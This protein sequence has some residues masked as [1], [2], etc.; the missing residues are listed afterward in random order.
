MKKSIFL[1]FLFCYTLASAQNTPAVILPGHTN[2]VD[3]VS[4]SSLGYIASGSFDYKINI[5]AADSPFTR[6]R[7]LTGHV[8]PVNTLRFSKNGKLLASSGEDHVVLVWDS[9][10]RNS[11]RLEG[12][13]DKVTCLAFDGYGRY[14]YSGSDDKNV[15]VWDMTTGKQVKTIV[16][17]TGVVAIAPTSDF[18]YVYIAGSEP[19]IKLYDFLTGKVAKSLDGHTD[20][21]NDIKISP[22]GKYL[23]SG[24]NDKTARVWSLTTGKQVRILPVECWKVT[25]VAFSADSRYAITACNDGSVKV[26]EIETGKLISSTEN[27]GSL[28][29]CV[30]FGKDNTIVLLASML[31]NSTDYG[32]KILPSGIK[33]EVA[34]VKV[35]APV[36]QDSLNSNKLPKIIPKTPATP[37]NSGTNMPKNA[38]PKQ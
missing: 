25:T 15:I 14:L 3:A 26:W 4:Y 37:P 10:W 35:V 33:P 22:N 16:H 1:G 8:G 17:T 31:R 19:K 36:K 18:K 38:T 11:R 12:H 29:R 32:L 27:V 13:K 24:S 34:P 9:A 20:A 5:Y 2:D 6:L 23:L 7:T 28:A 21:V 30:S